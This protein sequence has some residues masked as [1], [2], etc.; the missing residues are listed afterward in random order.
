VGSAATKA[1]I[2]THGV[3]F[4]D[5]ALV[6]AR[7]VGAKGQNMVYNA[8]RLQGLTTRPQ[9]LLL[10]DEDGYTVCVS[11]V[12]PVPGRI[13][14]HV[15]HEAGIKVVTPAHPHLAEGVSARFVPRPRYYD[16]LRAS[17]APMTRLISAC[18]LDELNIWPWH[19]CAVSG[20][21]S[22]C[23]INKVSH[24]TPSHDFSSLAAR[25]SSAYSAWSLHRD[26]YVRE[27]LDAVE[28]ALADDCYDEHLHMILI[29]GNLPDDQLDDQ[30]RIYGDLA[31][32]LRRIPQAYRFA[33]GIVAVT[34]PP[35]DL[36]L[37][38]TMK[39]MGVDVIVL[40]LEAYT[41]EAFERHCPGKHRIG[42]NHYLRSLEESVRVFGRGCSWT[43]F[44][45]GLEEPTDLL[46]GC[47]RLAQLGITPG[48][49]VLHLDVGGAA[50]L[51]PPEFN[52]V[53]MFYRQLAAI[54]RKHELRPYYCAKALRT[55]LA[56]EAFDDRL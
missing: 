41:P 45:L 51:K 50:F 12:A 27:L 42:R 1:Y 52:T 15:S 36:A 54:Y 28:I 34:A 11:A 8:P 3:E 7:S 39:A 26:A 24:A 17:G 32:V 29:S 5:S 44:V 9:E 21:C 10:S 53:L 22:F 2:L 38:G 25:T 30:A 47:E 6:H 46:A 37:L 49:N 35:Q 19:D 23:G 20:T 18:G 31:D 14:A 4:S 16:A 33:E 13:P 48:A 40:N 43:N 55:S 56:N